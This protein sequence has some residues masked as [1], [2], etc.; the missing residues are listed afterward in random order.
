M[1]QT[2]GEGGVSESP[3]ALVK[4]FDFRH[5]VNGKNFLLCENGDDTPFFL[6]I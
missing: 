6:M 4:I 5:G 2:I 3:F 1:L